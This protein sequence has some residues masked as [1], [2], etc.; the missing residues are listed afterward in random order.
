M[1]ELSLNNQKSASKNRFKKQRKKIDFFGILKKISR[2]LA[3]V[4]VTSLV[5]LVCY[6]FYGF[7]GKAA[8]LKLER[9]EI[10]GNKKLTR[11]EVLATAAVK[12][13]DDLLSLK[14]T[15]MGEHLVKN[16]W[17]ASVRVKRNFPHS[18]FIDITEREPV[19]I[20]SMGYL[21]YMDSKGDIFKPLHE[22]DLLDYPVVTGLT[23]DDLVRDPAAAKETMKGV[24]ALLDQLKKE[25]QG[26]SL[27][28]I[29]EIHYDKGFGYTLFTVDRALPLRIGMTDFSE[30]LDRLSR[31]YGQLNQQYQSIDY[32]DLD[33]NDRIVV[34]KT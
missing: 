1:R 16:P 30:K 3:V 33:Y 11:D 23:E 19:G 5:F 13:G 6:E 34:K 27:A 17:I 20:V 21:Y 2:I 32:I 29:S 9:I 10:S 25:R 15:R 28:D 7:L 24:L 14:L 12:T 18:L 8:F 31:I 22:G 4:T 26:F